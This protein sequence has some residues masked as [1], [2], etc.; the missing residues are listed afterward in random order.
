[1]TTLKVLQVEEIKILKIIR[2]IGPNWNRF[3]GHLPYTRTLSNTYDYKKGDLLDESLLESIKKTY[4]DSVL[5]ENRI[6]FIEGELEER[7]RCIRGGSQK[8][9]TVNFFPYVDLPYERM[10]EILGKQMKS[11]LVD[12]TLRL[13]LSEQNEKF[14]YIYDSELCY[15]NYLLIDELIKTIQAV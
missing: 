1:M 12:L 2:V 11:Y 13:D 3:I 15:I 8:K 6:I 10:H 9:I 14:Q 7:L 4:P 5:V